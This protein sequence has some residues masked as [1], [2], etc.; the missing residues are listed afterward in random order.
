MDT[1]ALSDAG[2]TPALW[3]PRGQHWLDPSGHRVLHV[4]QALAEIADEG[5]EHE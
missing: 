5:H 4:D 2:W 1:Q 3:L